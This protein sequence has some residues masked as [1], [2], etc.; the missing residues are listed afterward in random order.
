MN[1]G[2]NWTIEA[3]VS[4]ILSIMGEQFIPEAIHAG[5]VLGTAVASTITI[6]YLRKFLNHGK[7]GNE[8]KT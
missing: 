4:L 3:V 1:E 2:K 7:E 5:F 8:N 6:H